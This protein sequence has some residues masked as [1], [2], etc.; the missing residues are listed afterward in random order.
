MVIIALLL[1]S[2]IT[3]FGKVFWNKISITWLQNITFLLVCSFPFER[4]PSIETALGPIRIGHILVLIGWLIFG[5][6]WVK[7]DLQFF[8]IR[9]APEMALVGGFFL[10]SLTSFF[11]I[12]NQ[13]RFITSIV[14]VL[15]SFSYLFFITHFGERIWAGFKWILYL[16]IFQIIFTFYQLIGDLA[17]LP[18]S[19]TG[20]KL[21]FQSHVFG[22][23]RVHTTFN[24]PSYFANALF[25][26]LFGFVFLTLSKINIFSGISALRFEILKNK[27]LY[28]YVL[29]I[30][31]LLSAFALTVAKSAWILLP[32]LLPFIAIMYIL[33]IPQRFSG[34][35]K[36]G[37]FS[38]IILI[39]FGITLLFPT[40]VNN[41]LFSLFSTTEGTS[42][43]A[44][45]RSRNFDSAVE[46]IENSPLIGIGPGQFGTKAQE[47]LAYNNSSVYDL[48]VKNTEKLIV[49]NMYP[50]VWLEYGFVSFALLIFLLGFTLY[51]NFSLFLHLKN[52]THPDQIMR[53]VV[54]FYFLTSLIQWNFIS[55]LY[56]NPIF[57]ALGMLMYLNQKN[58]LTHYA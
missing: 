1:I 42:A 8:K 24:E 4:I 37:F 34:R 6:L 38:A 19:L 43:T 49:F 53:F 51:K 25:F 18:G 12:A 35:A 52:F 5:L 26:G 41:T 7:K 13:S 54:G 56:I 36:I 31:G 3:I 39:C 14:A 44:F 28:F 33:K 50:E 27:F 29:I 10:F 47:I 32:I 48:D 55:P 40:Q 11:E 22:F 23:P 46:L 45:E 21:I 15:I 57:V 2:C 20:V 17:G 16:F 30:F 9:L 58:S